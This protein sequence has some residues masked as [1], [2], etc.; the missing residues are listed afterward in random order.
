[1][2]NK[3][4]P[5]KRTLTAIGVSVVIL[6]LFS[7]FLPRSEYGVKRFYSKQLGKLNSSVEAISKEIETDQDTKLALESYD[8]KLNEPLSVCK[9]I[10]SRYRK[11]EGKSF[12]QQTRETVDGTKKLCDDLTPILAYSKE[13]YSTLTPY[14][15]YNTEAWPPYENEEFSSHLAGT[16]GMIRKTLPRLEKINYPQVDDP[17]L[18]ELISQVK[19]AEKLADETYVTLTKNDATTG[20]NLAEQLRKDMRQD[21]SDFL[22]A[23][24][25][26]WN[27]TVEADSLRQ[28]IHQLIERI[29]S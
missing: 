24:Q 21:K 26:F 5:N 1:M 4:L 23:R 25:Y 27:N 14:L 12:K 11:I 3:N 9:K 8:K 18:G 19:S 10:Q 7:Y 28:V 15:I 6:M 20:Q 16:Q 29:K 13:L 17:A 2:P 22:N